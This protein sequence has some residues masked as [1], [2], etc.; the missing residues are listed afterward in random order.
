MR[1]PGSKWLRRNGRWL[2]SRLTGGALILGYHRIAPTQND[3]FGMCVRRENFEQ[4]LAVI[5]ERANPITLNQFVELQESGKLPPRS[6]IITFDDGYI[7][8]LL[9]ARPLLNQYRL[10]ATLFVATGFLGRL[11]WWDELAQL[12]LE[13]PDAP[14]ELILN[15]KGQIHNWQGIGRPAERYSLLQEI[16]QLLLSMDAGDRR[17]HLD[18][19]REW[20]G[21]ENNPAAT[22]DRR[23]MVE[24]ELR[25]MAA[26]DLITIGAHTVSHPRLTDLS[27]Q[28]QWE[29]INQSKRCLEA[30]L[31]R[32]VTLFSY[33]NGA[34][35]ETT[36]LVLK[37]AGFTAACASYNDIARP[38]IDPFQLPRFWV[39]DWDGVK[40]GRWLNHWL[41]G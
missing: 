21:L 28:R 25:Q 19:L 26:G 40:F 20:T 24:D 11:F 32:S 31:E 8:N 30:V 35:D 33:P 37:Q 27:V 7:D 14:P 39:P 38:G 18:Q 22:S 10:P 36:R 3:Y 9:H 23:C 6:I 41:A 12:V 17:E 34:Y 15:I 29:E 4:Q 13:S 2:R 16:Y 1:I 5:H